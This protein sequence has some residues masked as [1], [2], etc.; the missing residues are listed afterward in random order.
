MYCSGRTVEVGVWIDGNLPDYGCSDDDCTDTSTTGSASQQVWGI[1]LGTWTGHSSHRYHDGGPWTELPNQSRVLYAGKTPEEECVEGGGQWDGEYCEYNQGGSPIIVNVSYTSKYKL[2]SAE[3]GVLFDLD[4]DGVPEQ[5]A[6]TEAGSEV[7]FLALDRNGDGRITSGRELFGNYT[8]PGAPN[9]FEALRRLT[10]ETNGGVERGSVSSEDSIFARL[11]LWTD[12]NHN[13][14][15]ESSELRPLGDVVSDVGLGYRIMPRRDGHGNEFRLRGWVHT[16][17]AP[18]RNGVKSK[19]E[20]A[21]RTR[22][23]W[24]VFLVVQR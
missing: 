18:G 2:T 12:A 7:A 15:S 21:E 10:M 3:E 14:V 5:I 16:R 6:W 8:L 17:T 4:G 19:A 24:D 23:I 13:G 20:N 11:L 1:A 22:S 9:G